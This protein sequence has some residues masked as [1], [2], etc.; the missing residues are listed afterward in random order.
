MQT[1]RLFKEDVYKKEASAKVTSVAERDGKTIVTLDRT[2][3]FPTGGGQTCDLGTIAGIPVVDVYEYEDEIYHQL[4]GGGTAAAHPA[5]AAGDEVTLELDWARR[6]D[7]M[8]RH[9][10]EHILTGIF[11]REWGGTNRGFHMGDDYMTIDIA[12]EEESRVDSLTWEMCLEAER[13]TNEVITANLPMIT[14]HFD[15]FEEAAKEPM[16][17][18]LTVE[19]DI[20]LVGIGKPEYDWGC[21]ACCGTHP[22]TTGQVGLVKIF[23]LEHNKGMYRIYFEAGRRAFEKYQQQFEVLNTLCGKLSAGADDVLDKFLSLQEKNKEVRNQLHF[24][25]KDVLAKEAESILAE[26]SA[27]ASASASGGGAAHSGSGAAGGA[28]ADFASTGSALPVRKYSLLTLD[29]LVSLSREIGPSVRKIY[30]LV[31]EP[32]HTVLL[33]S[34][35]KK[36]DC[37][38]LVKENASIYNGK[39]GGNQTMARAIFTK[40]EYVDTFIDLIE[41]HLR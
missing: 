3:F 19:C 6:F 32:S 1:I 20:T 36:T 35:G 28:R 24:L 8:Q 27:S 15:T 29:D 7:N 21:V 13:L 40:D 38:K 18:K 26:L 30:F 34:D 39:G 31:H 5:L 37:G 16:R 9:C 22:S 17:K 23:K 33:V 41:K 2:I 11:Y 14:R 12:L 25:K 10:G 4:E